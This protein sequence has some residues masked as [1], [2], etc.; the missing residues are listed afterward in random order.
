[1]LMQLILNYGQFSEEEAKKQL[2]ALKVNNFL[3][4]NSQTSLFNRVHK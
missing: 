2:V 3:V 4:H 1:M